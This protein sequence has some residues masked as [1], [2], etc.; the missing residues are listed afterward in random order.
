MSLPEGYTQHITVSEHGNPLAIC[1]EG[2]GGWME[3]SIVEDGLDA[4]KARAPGVMYRLMK[5]RGEIPKGQTQEQ[6]ERELNCP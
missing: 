4:V 1:Y 5:Q 6:F 2:P 3:S